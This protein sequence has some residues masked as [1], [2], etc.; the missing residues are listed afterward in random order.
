MPHIGFLSFQVFT[1]FFVPFRPSKWQSRLGQPEKCAILSKSIESHWSFICIVVLSLGISCSKPSEQE[2]SKTVL[3]K[4]APKVADDASKTGGTRSIVPQPRANSVKAVKPPTR[5][6]KLIRHSGRVD[7]PIEYIVVEPPDAEPET[8]LVVALHGW[9]DSPERFARLAEDLDL[10]VR[11]IVARGRQT[12]PRRGRAW[13]PRGNVASA[14]LERATEDLATLLKQLGKRYPK[15]PAP[16]IYG[17]SQG[18]MLALELL[19]SN[20]TCCSGVAALSARFV[21][22]AERPLVSGKTAVF[23]SAGNKDE[24]VSLGDTKAAKKRLEDAGHTV[25]LV[26]FDGRHTVPSVARLAL[27]TYIE[28]RL[29]LQRKKEPAQR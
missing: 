21:R 4:T 10:R 26:T 16:L 25:E 14:E 1:L 2:T 13:F 22:A 18:G 23:L 17:F 20:P 11:T 5:E 19:G 3:E 29:G 12:G 27:R 28:T 8:P 6:Q 15:A 24:V 7:G 9:G